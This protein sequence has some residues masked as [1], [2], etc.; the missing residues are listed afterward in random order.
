MITDYAQE[1]QLT[2]LHSKLVL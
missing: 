2:F 1:Y